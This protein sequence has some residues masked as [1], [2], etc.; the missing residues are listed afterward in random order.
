MA[1]PKRLANVAVALPAVL[2]STTAEMSTIPRLII[3]G[4]RASRLA[5]VRCG[6]VEYCDVHRVVSCGLFCGQLFAILL[7][8]IAVTTETTGMVRPNI[9]DA[10]SVTV[11]SNEALR[12]F[13][14]AGTLACIFKCK[15][16]FLIRE[17][18]VV[19]S[20][21]LYQHTLAQKHPRQRVHPWLAAGMSVPSALLSR[22][23]GH[24]AVALAAVLGSEIAEMQ[25]TRRSI[26]HGPKVSRLAKV[27]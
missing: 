23:R 9:H 15:I 7:P 14:I 16:I 26:I 27:S 2:G 20:L 19:A 22:N 6:K 21:V 12:P 8:C 11:V 4:P 13:I 5:K 24:L 3:H 18:S 1:L 17:A 25:A 10:P